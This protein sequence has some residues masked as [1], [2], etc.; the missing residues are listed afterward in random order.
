MKVKNNFDSSWEENY[1]KGLALN[2]YPYGELVSIFFNSLKYANIPIKNILEVGCGAGNNLWFVGELGYKVF[3]VDGS[4]T[5]VKVA[6]ENCKKRQVEAD[7]RHAYFQDLPFTDNSMDMVIDRES[8]YCGMKDDI[9]NSLREVARVLKPGGVFITFRFNDKNPT[10]KLLESRQILGDKLETGTYT[11][12]SKGTFHGVGV[13]NFA[14][15]DE[16]KEQHDFLDIAFIND[17]TSK[18]IENSSGD[19]EFFYSEYILVGVKT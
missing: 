3:G 12:I 11:N 8:I 1:S 2:K 19:N 6:K 9:Y 7:I 4:E 16:M 17:H 14:S 10:L 15:L 18:T 5:V 13:V